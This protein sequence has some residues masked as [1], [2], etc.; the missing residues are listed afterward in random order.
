MA[1]GGPS[2]TYHDILHLREEFNSNEETFS[3]LFGL[4][5]TQFETLFGMLQPAINARPVR[6]RNKIIRPRDQTALFLR[7]LASGK[8]YSDLSKVYDFPETVI[9]AVVDK[10]NELVLMRLQPLV[11]PPI[12]KRLWEEF[13]DDFMTI[14][15]MPHCLGSVYGRFLNVVNVGIQVLLL[16]INAKQKF[17][18]IDVGDYKTLPETIWTNSKLGNQFEHD[19]LELPTEQ[20]LG[21]Y[22]KKLPYVLVGG[23]SF[24]VRPYLIK[25]F[26]DAENDT[27]K[28]FDCRIDS[29]KSNAEDAVTR[30]RRR[31]QFIQCPITVPMAKVEGLVTSACCLE[32]YFTTVPI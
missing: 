13:A 32:N 8:C 10:I 7:F 17:V 25:K 6:H 27:K 3:E 14:H 16:I 24:P 20:K 30:L 26:R 15:K 2:D 11:M 31:W 4:N 28:V 23:N 9:G 29:V 18:M 22:K 1:R 19:E 21:N 12:S 5:Q